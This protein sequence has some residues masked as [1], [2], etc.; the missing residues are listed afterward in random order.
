[1]QKSDGILKQNDLTDSYFDT[2]IL[3]VTTTWSFIKREI[4]IPGPGG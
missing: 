2:L 4:L 3:H 1:M